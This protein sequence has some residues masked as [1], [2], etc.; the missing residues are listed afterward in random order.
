MESKKPS[1]FGFTFWG[2]FKSSA[3]QEIQ[4]ELSEFH[5]EVTD[6]N[7][8]EDDSQIDHSEEMSRSNNKYRTFI[9]DN[10]HVEDDVSI[11]EEVKPSS[12]FDRILMILTLTTETISVS[13]MV[14]FIDV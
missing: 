3:S 13:L 14:N 5:D 11:Q 7:N 4:Y 9:A 10:K 12:K 1:I 8:D 6:F 2:L